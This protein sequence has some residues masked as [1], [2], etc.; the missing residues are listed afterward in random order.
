[1]NF[2]DQCNYGVSMNLTWVEVNLDAISHNINQ[3][4][5]LVESKGSKLLA[6]I[7]D[8]AYGH[9]AIEVAKLANK[10]PVH[11]LGVA[12]LVEAIELRQSGVNSPILVLGTTF[13]DHAEE[14]IKNDI[15]QT[16]CDLKICKKLSETAKKLHKRAK[17]HIK[18]D[19]GMGRIGIHYKDAFNFIKAVKQ[20]PEID[21]EGIFTHFAVADIEESYTNLQIERFQSV[22]SNIEKSNIY[23]PIKHTAN[24]SS[25]M[26]FPASYF[27]M[28]RPG[29]AIYGIYPCQNP[30]IKIELK[31]A[32]SLKTKV[33]Y[34]KELPQGESISYG[35][36]Y[37][38]KRNTKIAT[39]AIGYGHGLSRKL[40]NTGEVIIRG[41][42]APIIGTICMDQSLC[43]ITHIQDVSVGDEVVVIGRQGNEE[44][45]VGDLADKIGTI[46]YEVLCNINERIPRLYLYDNFER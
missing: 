2:P 42:K 37:I 46:P 32:L 43:D 35:R 27:D 30:K 18:V 12:T 33:V 28:V 25:I 29:I 3:I 1:M 21:M 10:I 45:T 44:I 40:S 4:K 11:K 17:V 39:I 13:P 24:S 41:K 8:N 6:V 34:I 5:G 7:K 20:F 31:P 15:T 23:I 38:T 26:N 9:G 16:V 36:T 19:T 22:I 14:I